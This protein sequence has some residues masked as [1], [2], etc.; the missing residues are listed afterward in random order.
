MPTI[1]INSVPDNAQVYVQGVVDYSHITSII[2]GA[3][4]QQDNE[5]KLKNGM[6]PVDKPHTRMTISKAAVVPRDFNN[7]TLAEQYISEKLYRS[8][9]HPEKDFCYTC[10]NKSKTLP[11]VYCRDNAAS[12]DLE[13][14]L[15]EGEIAPG[16]K[17]T[18]LL[19]IFPTKQNKGVSLD[20][21]IVDEKPVR[22]NDRSNGLAMAG[23]LQERGFTVKPASAEQI[24]KYQEQLAAKTDAPAAESA[25]VYAQPA[26]PAQP[27]ATY[28]QPAAPVQPAYA[29]PAPAAPVYAQPA[30]VATEP[31]PAAPVYAQ[32]AAAP[33]QP[34][35]A[36]PAAPAPAEPASPNA[37]LP[38]PPA[39]YEYDEQGHLRASGIK[40]P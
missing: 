5:R 22:Y 11:E 31:A 35:Y 19:R 7:P 40:L 8:K 1:N 34:V 32:P 27:V 2:D 9:A 30:P 10:Y 21:V 33:A 38:K 15:P 6:R 37:N 23:A 39:G 24:A 16:V 26:A 18:L 4:L 13:Q 29:Q 28:A 25:P 17:V 3:E 14:V 20:A 36:Q 12:T